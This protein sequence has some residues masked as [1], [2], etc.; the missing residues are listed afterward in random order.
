M[1]LNQDGLLWE[2]VT[3]YASD[4]ENL[5]QGENNSVLTRV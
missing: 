4:G 2:N 3:G 1:A 5:M